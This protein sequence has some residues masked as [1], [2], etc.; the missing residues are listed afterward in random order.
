VTVDLG[1]SS[2]ST[3]PTIGATA[4]WSSSVPMTL[5]NSSGSL[6]VTFQTANAGGTPENITLAGA[7][8][9]TGGLTETGGGTLTLSGDNT[10]TGTTNVLDGV[11]QMS[12]TLTN[13]TSL[14]V[15]SGATFYLADG[16]LSVAGGITNNGIFKLSGTPTVS[17]TG[18]FINNGVLDLI[19]GPQT[20]PANFTNNG[21]VLYSNAVQ[22]QQL[23][24]NGSNFTLK[25][26]GYAQHTYQLQRTSSLA[27]PVTWTNVGA[28]QAGTGSELTLSDTG[29]GGGS[30]AFYQILVS[31]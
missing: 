31:P 28:P 19:D 5:A 6:P 30:Q 9:G 14:T 17:Q 10:Y 25:I 26:M 22:V 2:V 12:G 29:A 27:A 1:S 23:G 3:A 4:A 11:L 20:L 24:M 21:T 18:S 15:A 8:S 13:T 16:T 7:L